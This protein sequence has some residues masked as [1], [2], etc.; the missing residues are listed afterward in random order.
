MFGPVTITKLLSAAAYCKNY[1]QAS[2]SKCHAINSDSH[3][4]V[5]WP[6]THAVVGYGLFVTDLLQDGVPSHLDSQGIGELG[7][8]Y[9]TRQDMDQCIA[10]AAWWRWGTDYWPYSEMVHKWARERSRSSIATHS[11]SLYRHPMLPR[12]S[13]KRRLITLLVWGKGERKSTSTR[14][15]LLN[16]GK[17]E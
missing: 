6:T 8:N 7:P 9:G 15:L 3:A 11:E 17:P 12:M 5:M 2:C 1:N 4:T 10:S 16:P 13:C 14:S